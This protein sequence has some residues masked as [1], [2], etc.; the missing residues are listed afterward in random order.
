MSF[1]GNI[2]KLRRY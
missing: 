2:K 1:N